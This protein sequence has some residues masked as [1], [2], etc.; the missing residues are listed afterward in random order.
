MESYKQHFKFV[1]TA[2]STNN[3]DIS[4]IPR[5]VLDGSVVSQYPQEIY[6]GQELFYCIKTIDILGR[7]AY[8]ATATYIVRN[9][10]QPYIPKTTKLW[11]SFDDQEQ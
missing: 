3:Y 7:S 1:N 2:K 10:S 5:Q 9:N 4:S 6:P 11:L 8:S